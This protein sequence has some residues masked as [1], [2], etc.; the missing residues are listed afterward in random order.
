MEIVENYIHPGV[1][2]AL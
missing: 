2:G 1:I